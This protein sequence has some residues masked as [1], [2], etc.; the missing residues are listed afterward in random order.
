MNLFSDLSLRWKIPLRVMA[1]V[2]G[3]ALA[4]TGALLARDY[5]DMRQNLETHAKSIGRVL[6][7][8]L[9]APVLHDDLWR[10]FEILQSA[11]EAHPAA[12]ELEAE[13]MLVLDAEHRVFVASR[14]RDFPI[15]SRPEVL[16]GDFGALTTAI[17]GEDA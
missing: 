8:T 16:S 11:R 9:V 2:L 14:P 10:A 6:A 17:A 15:G 7:N 5:D 1:A 13:V 12:A 3:T 4:V